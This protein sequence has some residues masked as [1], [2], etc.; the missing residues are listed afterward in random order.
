MS[1]QECDNASTSHREDRL[2]AKKTS[3]AASPQAAPKRTARRKGRADYG[4][5]IGPYFERLPPE[6]RA[7]L[8]KLR[9]LVEETVPSAQSSL[10]WGV[11][12]YTLDGKM[13]AALGALKNQVA[14]SIYAPPEAFDDPKGQLEGKSPEYRV[15]KVEDGRDI[16]AASVKR[17][18]K[19]AVAA[20]K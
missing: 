7:P 2:A 13:L 5:P 4:A 20:A 9:A 14:L 11:P 3:G 15:L 17:W 18:L 1:P 10:K 19:A 6:K 16:D 8:E 12:F